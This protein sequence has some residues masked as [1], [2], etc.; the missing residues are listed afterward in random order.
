MAITG[1]T[2]AFTPPLVD[3]IPVQ[4]SQKLTL[5]AKVVDGGEIGMSPAEITVLPL[6]TIETLTLDG[7]QL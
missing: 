4:L 6:E 2:G 5:F 1:T 3:E 7:G